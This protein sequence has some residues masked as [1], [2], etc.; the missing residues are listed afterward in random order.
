[1]ATPEQ[2]ARSEIDR[3]LAAAGWSVQDYKSAD[4]H[5]SRGVALREFQLKDG[6]GAADYLLYVDGK[7]DG[8][9]A[10]VI[11]AK[12]KG[13]TLT[14]V[15]IQSDRYTKGMPD[16]LP[17]WRDPLP[18]SYRS[19]GI[20]GLITDAFDPEPRLRNALPFSAHRRIFA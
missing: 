7:V 8:K 20:D 17:R 14:G 18:F 3:L 19:T 2:Q 11:E 10:G 16:G 13:A 12:R 4:L 5:A 1:M 9:A 6:Y 15:E